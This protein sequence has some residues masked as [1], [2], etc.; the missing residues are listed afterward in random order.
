MT[1]PLLALVTIYINRTERA[2]SMKNYSILIYIF[3]VFGTL[4]MIA[5]FIQLRDLESLGNVFFGLV[6][7]TTFSFEQL[8]K[9]KN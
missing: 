4:S 9:I 6:I 1:T 8:N 5:R 2:R 7:M 3:A